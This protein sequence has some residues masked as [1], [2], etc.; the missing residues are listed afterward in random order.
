MPKLIDAYLKFRSQENG[1]GLPDTSNCP[2]EAI[3]TPITTEVIDIF[4]E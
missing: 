2:C 4:C 1:E 3:G